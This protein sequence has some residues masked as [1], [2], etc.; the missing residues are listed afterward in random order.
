MLNVPE[1]G[2][3]RLAEASVT[4]PCEGVRMQTSM[5]RVAG[6]RSLSP[7]SI[8]VRVSVVIFNLCF[9]KGNVP[10]FNHSLIIDY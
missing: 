7:V 5:R 2:H 3:F 1:N 10:R 8:T 9:G 6:A 4:A